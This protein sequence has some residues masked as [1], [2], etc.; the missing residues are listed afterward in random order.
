MGKNQNSKKSLGLPNNSLDQ[1]I[2]PGKI[3]QSQ[4]KFSCTLFVELRD[5]DTRVLPVNLQIVLNAQKFPIQIKLSKSQNQKYQPPPPAKKFLDHSRHFKSQPRP[6]GAFPKR[7]KSALGTRLF[8]SGLPPM[9]RESTL[10]ILVYQPTK[11]LIKHTVFWLYSSKPDSSGCFWYP[12]KGDVPRHLSFH[13]IKP[14]NT[15]PT[16]TK[17]TM[18]ATAMAHPLGP[19]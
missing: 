7:G 2:N 6:Q 19:C 1:K 3:Q 5:R 14:A 10:M 11:I 8:K 17:V 12:A 13:Q 18:T 15:R 16:T 4:N 9:R